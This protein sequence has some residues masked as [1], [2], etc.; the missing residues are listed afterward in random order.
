MSIV[1]VA[2]DKTGFLSSV[3]I[4]CILLVVTVYV[5][6]QDRHSGS[7][8]SSASMHGGPGMGRPAGRGMP[9]APVQ[10]HAGKL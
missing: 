2:V 9:P 1:V 7:H 5:F 4:Y 6:T 3:R 10:P 8:G